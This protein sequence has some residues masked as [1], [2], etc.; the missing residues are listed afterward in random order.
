MVVSQ[1]NLSQGDCAMILECLVPFF[2][3]Y[4]DVFDTALRPRL[5]YRFDLFGSTV[6]WCNSGIFDLFAQLKKSSIVVALLVIPFYTL[7]LI[8]SDHECSFLPLLVLLF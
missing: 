8:S 2:P 5:T 6:D 3:S 4:S 7:V 1:L